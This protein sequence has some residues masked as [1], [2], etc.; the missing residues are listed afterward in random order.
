MNTS[1]QVICG[2]EIKLNLL[3][4][5]CICPGINTIISCLITSNIPDIPPNVN[6]APKNI[7]FRPFM[8]EYLDGMQNEVY[9]I[10]LEP[11]IFNGIAFM[12][13]ALQ[14]YNDFNIMLIAVEM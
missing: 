6:N 12:T 13:A 10:P 2:E 5:S 8:E 9:R 14:L 4:K 3:G 1:D 7:G 11:H